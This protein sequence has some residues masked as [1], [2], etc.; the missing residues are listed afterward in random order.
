MSK[1]VCGAFFEIAPHVSPLQSSSSNH[2]LVI[3]I[4][5]CQ[6]HLMKCDVNIFKIESALHVQHLPSGSSISPE[7]VSFRFRWMNCNSLDV[8]VV[9]RLQGHSLGIEL[10]F[11]HCFILT[12]PY[13][14]SKFQ[15]PGN[16][17]VTLDAALSNI[18]VA[19]TF[20]LLQVYHF[21]IL[22]EVDQVAT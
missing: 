1:L 20:W 2:L 18:S 9:C 19:T 8:V 6:D 5:V 14:C 17:R 21:H 15:M 22:P 13:F 12:L 7:S 11:L 3:I 4:G 10:H 16:G